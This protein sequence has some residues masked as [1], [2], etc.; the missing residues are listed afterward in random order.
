MAYHGRRRDMHDGSSLPQAR[1]KASVVVDLCLWICFSPSLSYD[2]HSV[3]VAL[4][5][6]MGEQ[7]QIFVITRVR[8]VGSGSTKYRCVAAYKVPRCQGAAALSCLLH[9]LSMV[10]HGSN[11]E[12]IEPEELCYCSWMLFRPMPN[13][14]PSLRVAIRYLLGSHYTYCFSL[15]LSVLLRGLPDSPGA[16]PWEDRTCPCY[17]AVHESPEDYQ[18]STLV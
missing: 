5:F 17:Q 14:T 7:F 6:P 1:Q 16:C 12:V 4:R 10:K 13:T 9:F 18:S 15:F 8:S 11:R 2:K 3:W